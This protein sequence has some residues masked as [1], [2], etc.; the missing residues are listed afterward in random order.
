MKGLLSSLK[1][2][3]SL[4]SKVTIGTTLVGFSI[5][6][7]IGG[8]NSRQNEHGWEN[9]QKTSIK[10]GMAFGG[11]IGCALGSIWQ[12]TIPGSVAFYAIYKANEYITF[13]EKK[14]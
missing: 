1:N 5:G 8:R 4:T 11:S 6:G 9:D 10:L 14:E 7:Y 2:E 13:K 3:I 12:V